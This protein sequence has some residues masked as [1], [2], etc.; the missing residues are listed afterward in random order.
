[1]AELSAAIAIDP[2]AQNSYIGRG[3]AEV[4]MINVDAAI[5]DF[6]KAAQIAPSPVALFRLGQALETKGENQQAIKAY[7]AALQLAPGMAEASARLNFLQ[8][9]PQ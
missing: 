6:A 9:K 3:T 5:A 1:V 4:Q 2:N 8:A 7:S